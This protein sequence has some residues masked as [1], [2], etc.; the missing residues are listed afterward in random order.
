MVAAP[1]L[2][3]LA[4]LVRIDSPGPVFFR[5]ERVGRDG[6]PFQMF[7]FRSMYHHSE[8]AAH[9]AAAA[10]WFSGRA[11]DGRYKS[12]ADPR[13]T[14]VG[15]VLRATSLDEL[16]QLLNVLNGT[17]SLV[18][19][20]PAIAY[21]LAYYEPWYFDRQRVKPGMTGLWQV[22]GR[23]RVSAET[24]MRLD[25]RYVREC[26]PWLDMKILTLTV[27]AMLGWTSSSG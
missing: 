17:M 24:M 8:D 4:L 22:S 21:E 20:R 3:V 13:I 10:A 26:S 25:L 7:K 19:P 11:V 2:A 12:L 23:D 16:P 1:L 9:R 5:Q 6:V 15:R 27:P 18:G 14:R